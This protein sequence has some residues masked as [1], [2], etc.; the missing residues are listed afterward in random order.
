[1]AP[2]LTLTNFQREESAGWNKGNVL[3]ADLSVP[4]LSLDVHNTGAVA[5]DAT[6]TDHL[7]GSKAVTGVSGDCFDLNYS[8][9]PIGLAGTGRLTMVLTVP[10]PA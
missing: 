10:R 6:L 2:G 1:M 5:G 9:A 3:T 4:T 8:G 7:E